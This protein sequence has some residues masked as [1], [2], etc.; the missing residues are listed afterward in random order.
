MPPGRSVRSLSS[1]SLRKTAARSG[2]ITMISSRTIGPAGSTGCRG[3][4]HIRE[5]V[6]ERFTGVFDIGHG[7]FRFGC[8]SFPA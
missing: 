2:T 1:T 4:T 3:V 5:L 6:L 7:L 8:R